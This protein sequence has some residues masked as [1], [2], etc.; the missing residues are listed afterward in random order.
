MNKED[1]YLKSLSGSILAFLVVLLL[2]FNLRKSV[3]L[4]SGLGVLALLFLKVVVFAALFLIL[5]VKSKYIDVTDIQ[6]FKSYI[7]RP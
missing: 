6:L 7:G 5:V 4:N 1:I 2:S 3:V